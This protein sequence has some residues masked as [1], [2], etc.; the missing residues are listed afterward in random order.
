MNIPPLLLALDPGSR[1][2]G[3]ALFHHGANGS[4]LVRSEYLAYIGSKA[5]YPHGDTAADRWGCAAMVRAWVSKHTTLWH[6]RVSDCTILVEDMKVYAGAH[7]RGDPEDLLRLQA[8]SYTVLGV[9]ASLGWAP[10][11]VKAGTWN[12]QVPRE[13]RMARTRAWLESRGELDRLIVPKVEPRLVHNAWSAVGIGRW[14]VDP[15]A[16]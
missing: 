6:V 3:V 2:C 14:R 7:S 12:G 10:E 4:T 15:K 9:F 11:S 1:G 8:V 13:I 16:R 5:P